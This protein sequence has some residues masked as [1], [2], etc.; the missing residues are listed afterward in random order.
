MTQDSFKIILVDQQGTKASAEFRDGASALLARL[1]DGRELM[2]DPTL[3]EKRGDFYFIP[4]VFDHYITNQNTSKQVIIPILEEHAFV[5]K[6]IVERV[7]LR[8]KKRVE[9]EEKKISVPLKKETLQFKRVP[10]NRIVEQ[11]ASI[12]HEDGVLIIPVH[13]ER[14]VLQKQ[15]VLVEE[16]YVRQESD[17]I[18]SVHTV[19]LRRES[20]EIENLD[21]QPEN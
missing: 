4:I 14:L 13:E 1:E 19:V 9:S 6:T 18:E 8:L 2:L 5:K 17:E 10:V 16:L 12:R 3:L 7:Q 15:L 11:P 21:D 20:I